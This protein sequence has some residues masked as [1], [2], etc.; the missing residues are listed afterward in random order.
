MIYQNYSI[1]F[2]MIFIHHSYKILADDTPFKFKNRTEWS[3]NCKN[4]PKN[5]HSFSKTISAF[6]QHPEIQD[7]KKLAWQ[8]FNLA[9]SRGIRQL[10]K[11]IFTDKSLWLDQ[12]QIPTLNSQTFEPYVEKVDLKV[13]DEIIIHGDIHSFI[14]ELDELEQKGYFYP[15]SFKLKN[16]NTKLLFLGDYV[17]RGFYG[18]E[19]IYTLLRL[20]ISNPEN[21]IIVRGNHEDQCICNRYGFLEELKTTFDIDKNNIDKVYNLYN[22]FPVAV[23][24]G[25]NHNYLQCCHGGTEH[26]YQPQALLNSSSKFE[27]IKLLKR[28]S[29]IEHLH[30]SNQIKNLDGQWLKKDQMVTNIEPITPINRKFVLGFMWNDFLKTG[31]SLFQRGLT[32][33]ENLTK[34]ILN[35][36]N[37]K[38]LEK[39][40]GIIRAH[41]HD[42]E[43]NQNDPTNLMYELIESNGVY[44]HWR[45]LENTQERSLHNGIVWTF[46]ASP[47]SPSG[48]ANKKQ[49]L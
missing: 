34:A 14:A 36:Q 42:Q 28:K 21:V 2:L 16:K 26:G 45:P 20:K 38:S 1:F 25:H 35:F 11:E 46:N 7:N 29:F 8:E 13:N 19:V 30:K 37:E 47:D 17:D 40:R 12:Q 49:D 44:K 48:K 24:I 33:N 31:N 4:L 41:Q 27:L 9:L 18:S 3:E 10:D 15:S 23:Y 5:L 32:C 39:V 43:I 22:F 6:A